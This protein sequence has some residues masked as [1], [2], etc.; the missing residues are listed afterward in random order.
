MKRLAVPALLGFAS[1]E[2]PEAPAACGPIPDTTVKAGETT[3]AAACFSDPN[4]DVLSYSVV[5]SDPDVATVSIS[6]SIVTV[7]AV[8]PGKATVTVTAS[9]PGGLEGQ[10][11]FSVTVPHRPQR[12]TNER[13]EWPKWSPDGEKIVF[14]SYRYG[15]GFEFDIYVIQIK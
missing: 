1:C 2:S 10:Q 4:G 14:Q 7:A 9:D 5:S 13:G 11:T 8:A 3:T 15:E 12:L 6:V